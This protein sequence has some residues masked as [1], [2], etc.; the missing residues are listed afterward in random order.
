MVGFSWNNWIIVLRHIGRAC[1]RRPRTI[2]MTRIEGLEDR[3]LLTANLPVA[4]ND[5][6]QVTADTT[7]NSPTSVLANDTDA[8]GD[9]IDQVLLNSNVSHGTLSLASDGTFAYTPTT[10]FSGVDSFTYFARDAA[11][12]ENSASPATVTL[13]VGSSNHTP[14]ARPI[15]IN[16]AADTPFSGGLSADDS[17]ND[18]LTFSAGST[19]AIH[20]AVTIN[21][22]GSFTYTP[23]AGYIGPDSF[24]FKV[25]DGTTDSA[26]AVVTVN[27]GTATDHAPT[28]TSISINVSKDTQFVGGLSGEDV[29]GDPLTFAQGHT[30]AAHGTVSISLN[31]NFTYTP[32]V[33]YTGADSFS[34]LVSDGTFSSANDGVVSVQ[35]ANP[36]SGNA[37]PIAD[38]TSIQVGLNTTF[39]G[40]LSGS[41]ADGDPLTFSTGSVAAQHGSVGINSN[42]SFTYTPNTGYTGNDSFSFKVNDG[43]VNSADALVSVTVGGTANHPPVAAPVTINDVPMN[44]PFTGTLQGS[45][46]DGDALT[47]S[48]GSTAPAHGTVQIAPNGAFTY[49]PNNGF[50]GTDSFS[51]K[52]NDGTVNSADALVTLHISGTQ[53]TAPVATAV[54]INVGLNTTFTGGLSG[55]DADGDPLAFSAGS[56]APAHG[57]LN[58]NVDGSFSYTPNTNYSGSDAFSFKVNDGTVNSADAL[59][60]IQVGTASN[61]PPVANPVSITVAMNTPFAGGLSGSDADGDPLTF[62]DGA[63][64]ASHG[65]VH[66]NTNGSF[67]YTPN[68]GYVGND[69]FS[70]KVNDGTASSS[71]AIVTVHVIATGNSPPIATPVSINVGMNTTFS[72]FLSGTDADGD[73]LTFAL[74]TTHPGHGTVNIGANGAF[75]YTPN[76]NFTGSDSFSFRVNDGTVNSTDAL[77]SIQVGTAANTPP[78]ANSTSISVTLNTLFSGTL[79]GSDVDGDPL[80]FSAGSVAAAH[81]SVVINSNGSFLYNPMPGFTG[82][83]VF[84]FKVNDGSA[85]SDDGFVFVSVGN[86]VNTPPVADS[87]NI[88][89]TTNTTF[90][91]TLTATDADNDLLTFLAG[92]IA[93]SHGTVLISA[94]GSFTYTPDTGFAGSDAFSFKVN[95]GNADSAEAFV[96]VTA[97]A[98]SNTPPVAHPATISTHEGVTLSGSLIGTDADGDPLTFSAGATAPT[99]G[100]VTVNSNGTFTYTPNAGFAGFDLFT[101]KVNDGTVNSPAGNVIIHVIGTANLAPTVSNGSGNVAANVTFDGSVSPLAVDPEGDPLAFTVVT[102]PTHGSLVLNPDGTFAYIPDTDFVGSD[103]FTFKANDGSTDS[104]V[105][106]FNLAMSDIAG[107]F[108]LVLSDNPGSISTSRNVVPLDASASLVN[109]DPTLNFANAAVTARITSGASSQDRFV[110]TDGGSTDIRGRKIRINGTEVARI[111]GGRGGHALE[112]A[113]NSNATAETVQAVIDRIG[114]RT[115]RRSGNNPRTVQ[116]TVNADGFR[117]SAEIVASKV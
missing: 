39:L 7:F 18:S 31:G 110:L 72:G 108:T 27:V 107:G 30:L 82:S 12:S 64:A 57:T 95:D 35:V 6:Y 69:T 8:D 19:Q 32:D 55:T 58:I 66:I 54:S 16:V 2:T 96:S 71:D 1:R 10:G 49:T 93:A 62:L 68:T 70:F 105:A 14:V 37:A 114:L 29:D 74:G 109:V 83:D 92:S 87:V 100:S 90:H 48:A 4:A 94:N 89:V 88:N 98:A 40:G 51:F 23:G 42:G 59:V 101:F 75:T 116:I 91:G 24:S 11:N 38:A 13:T 5:T 113:F 22:D 56:T 102:P 17:D 86:G 9:T 103:F 46:S 65:T 52:V 77:V 43:T 63:I 117:S 106:T 80:T 20:G 26:D 33:G 25:N 45:D 73:P 47:F 60:S 21:S 81:G 44:A 50:V 3:A 78:T 53:N 79:A 112:I 34:F 67:T 36:T 99:H 61:T 28:A 84:S 41:D 76:A 111:S 85:D 115:T 15:T 104:N 97:G